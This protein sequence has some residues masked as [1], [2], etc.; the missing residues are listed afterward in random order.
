GRAVGPW[1][2]ASARRAGS[3][4][5]VHSLWR[6]PRDGEAVLSR[7]TGRASGPGAP[8]MV[9]AVTAALVALVVVGPAFRPG[10]VLA[11]D[12]AWSPDSRFTPFALGTAG[13][14]PR[15][16]PSDAV[17]IALGQVLGP[18]VAQSLVLW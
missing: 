6:R 12:L 7:L 17:A 15:A 3:A 18:G 5:P 14:A 10:V 13:P 2:S 4:G 9:P 16:V 8:T 1:S 11:C